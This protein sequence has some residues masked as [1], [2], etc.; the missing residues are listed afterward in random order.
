MIVI[1]VLGAVFAALAVFIIVCNGIGWVINLW[2][3]L[4][5]PPPPPAPPKVTFDE[6][7]PHWNKKP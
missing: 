5:N 6:D 1:N 4:F 7:L 3:G 2:D